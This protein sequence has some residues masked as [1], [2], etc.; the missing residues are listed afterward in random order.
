MDIFHFFFSFN[1]ESVCGILKAAVL[2]MPAC[3]WIIWFLKVKMARSEQTQYA[4]KEKSNLRKA[5][6]EKGRKTNKIYRQERK[7]IY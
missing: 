4:T 6:G 5:N 3:V 1:K 7:K 2:P